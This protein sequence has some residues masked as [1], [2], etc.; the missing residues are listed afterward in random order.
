MPHSGST[1]FVIHPSSNFL[2][3]LKVVLKK[4]KGVVGWC[5]GV[6]Y[7]TSPG[8][9]NDIGLKLRRPAILVAGKG[10]GGMFLFLLF[11]HRVSKICLSYYS[12]ALNPRY[13]L[14]QV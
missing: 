9:P 11:L 13:K 8:R 2:T 7:L 5:K 1:P 10:I 3:Y 6:V 4:K 14:C 12:L